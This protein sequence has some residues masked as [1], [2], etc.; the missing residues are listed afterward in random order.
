MLHED[1]RVTTQ[2][3][4]SNNLEVKMAWQPYEL[5]YNLEQDAVF[6][7]EKRI[8]TPSTLLKT[9]NIVTWST[10]QGSQEPVVFESSSFPSSHASP[11][12]A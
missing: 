1:K 7:S 8:Q 12:Q 2:T 10:F 11:D 3:V 6:G 9:S 5:T 4:M